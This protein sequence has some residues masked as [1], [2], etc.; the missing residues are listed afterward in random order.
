MRV[1]IANPSENSVNFENSGLDRGLNAAKAL[2]SNLGM[3]TKSCAD[4]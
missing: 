2:R 4:L 1:K 3:L